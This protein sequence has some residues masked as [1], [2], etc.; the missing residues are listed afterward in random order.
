MV[1]VELVEK[2]DSDPRDVSRVRRSITSELRREGVP[3]D[4]LDVVAL[5]VSELVTN[6]IRHGAPPVH[7]RA[8]H[9]DGHVTV[10]VDDAGERVPVPVE[11]TSWDASGGRG[12]HLVE[13]LADG[14]GVA[15]NGRGKRVWFRVTISA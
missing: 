10:I 1:G 5:L 7:L 12:L 15:P 8:Q 2:V 9:T 6:A 4:D 13:A 14:W 3:Q 11:D